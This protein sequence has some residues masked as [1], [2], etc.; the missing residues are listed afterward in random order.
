MTLADRIR[1]HVIAYYINPAR[2]VGLKTVAI[3]IRCE[4]KGA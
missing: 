3:V 1:Q 4:I 2:K